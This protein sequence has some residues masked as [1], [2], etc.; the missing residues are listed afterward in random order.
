MKKWYHSRT[1]KIALLQGLMG[2]LLAVFSEYPE[3]QNVGYIAV[4]KSIIDFLLRI[5]T[6]QKVI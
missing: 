2:V 5:N 6:E 4:V 1:I 3:L